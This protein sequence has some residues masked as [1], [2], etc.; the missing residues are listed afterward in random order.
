M[1]EVFFDVETKKLFHEIESK[2]PGGLGISI[3]SV[4]SREVDKTGHEVAGTMHSFWEKDFLS[5]WK[6]FQNADRVIGFNT[7]KFDVPALQPYATFSLAKLPHFDILDEVKKALGHRLSLNA[8][9]KATLDVQKTDSGMNA[10]VY[11]NNGDLESLHKLQSYCESDVL[12][13]RDL[14]DYGVGEKVLK[15]IDKWN[16]LKTFPI[17][18]SYPQTLIDTGKQTSLF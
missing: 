3:V 11:W 15:Y 17:D 4:Y 7:L 13:T 14:Y 8:L 2:D 9:G 16:N 6:L 10:V 12:L 1:I 18:C 5:M